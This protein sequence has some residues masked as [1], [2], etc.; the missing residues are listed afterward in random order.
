MGYPVDEGEASAIRCSIYAHLTRQGKG[1]TITMTHKNG[2]LYI[3]TKN[4][5]RVLQ[6][7]NMIRKL[8]MHVDDERLYEEALALVKNI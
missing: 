1:G 5:S 8:A 2:M 3:G 6:L 7:E 4:P